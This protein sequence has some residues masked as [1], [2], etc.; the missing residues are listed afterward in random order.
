MDTPLAPRDPSAA[1]SLVLLVVFLV[2]LG[3]LL[4]RAFTR[5][6]DRKTRMTRALVE[7]GPRSLDCICCGMPA[8]RPVSRT[9]EPTWLDDLFPAWR[10]LS[11]VAHYRPAIPS[12][13]IPQLCGLCGRA[14]DARLQHRV[15]EVVEL[16][17]GRMMRDVADQMNAYEGGE[18]L[19]SLVADLPA[20]RKKAK[21][22]REKLQKQNQSAPATGVNTVV[23]VD[24]SQFAP[25][26]VAPETILDGTPPPQLPQ[27]GTPSP[28]PPVPPAPV[29]PPSVAPPRPEAL[30]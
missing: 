22:E 23:I 17:R 5:R 28:I 12:D 18:L 25:R 27:N 21:V 9:G 30:S 24:P 7:M 15:V 14:W 29:T 13:G 11:L 8:E 6:R 1:L 3:I 16:A 10:R 20:A 2:S 19:A 4:V 26:G